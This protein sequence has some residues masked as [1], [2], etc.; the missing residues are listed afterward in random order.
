MLTEGRQ[1]REVLN[2][3]PGDVFALKTSDG[4]HWRYLVLGHALAPPAD[5]RDCD[6]WRQCL[7]VMTDKTVILDAAFHKQRWKLV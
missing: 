1:P 6:I 3:E 4:E 5:P 2:I 7:L